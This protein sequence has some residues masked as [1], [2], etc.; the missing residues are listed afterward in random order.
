MFQFKPAIWRQSALYEL[1]RPVVS[2]RI[3]DTW[4]FARFKVPLLDGDALAGHSRGG[5]DISLEGEFAMRDGTVTLS[6]AEMF[7]A[8]EGLRSALHVAAA[9]ETYQFFLYHDA[10]TATYR[11]FKAC[12]TVRFEYDLSHKTLFT[13]AAVIHAADPVLHTTAPA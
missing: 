12:S 4:D 13:Y 2:L 9:A 7:A 1:P 11:S 8:M 3:Q 10:A 6:E 5:V